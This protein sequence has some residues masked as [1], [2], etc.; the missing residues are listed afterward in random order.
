MIKVRLSLSR[1]FC[2][3]VIN[4]LAA[5]RKF[6]YFP[7]QSFTLTGDV[8]YLTCWEYLSWRWS[9]LSSIPL[10]N[11]STKRS[12][13][14]SNNTFCIHDGSDQISHLSEHDHIADYCG[15]LI[16]CHLS[17]EETY[18]NPGSLELYSLS[19]YCHFERHLILKNLILAS[20]AI[21]KPCGIQF[22]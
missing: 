18:I 19:L 10:G 11:Y 20:W 1:K 5:T 13:I 7:K 4:G 17:K 22:K 21:S 14:T 3:F 16:N 2:C 6:L 12:H 8:L 9:S 15:T